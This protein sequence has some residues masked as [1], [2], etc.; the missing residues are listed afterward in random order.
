[1]GQRKRFLNQ[2]SLR[3]VDFSNFSKHVDIVALRI[4]S[5]FRFYEIVKID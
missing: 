5:S 2:Q 1:M 4:L 3:K